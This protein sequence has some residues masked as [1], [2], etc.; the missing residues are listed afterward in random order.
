VEPSQCNR[1]LAS[2]LSEILI[3]AAPEGHSIKL[4]H[5]DDTPQVSSSVEESVPMDTDEKLTGDKIPE[6]SADV[7]PAQPANEIEVCS[8]D[9]HQRLQ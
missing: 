8:S 6:Q 3:Q 9:F 1:I 5:L 2:A 7:S 4:V